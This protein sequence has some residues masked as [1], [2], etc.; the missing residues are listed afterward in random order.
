MKL[1][2]LEKILSDQPAF[3]LQ[4]AKQAVFVNL[5]ENWSQATNLPPDLREKLNKECPLKIDAEFFVSDDKN[6]IKAI[7]SLSDSDRIE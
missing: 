5:I 6:T 2:N 3:R 7:L 1:T 4:Q